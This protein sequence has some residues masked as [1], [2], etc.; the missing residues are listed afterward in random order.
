MRRIEQANKFELVLNM[1]ALGMGSPI[2]AFGGKADM[3]YCSAN[4]RL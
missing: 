3:V 1:E 4:V 2:S